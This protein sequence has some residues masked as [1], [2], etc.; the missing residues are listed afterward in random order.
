[1]QNFHVPQ[2]F[3]APP[4]ES[5]GGANI[6]QVLITMTSLTVSTQQLILAFSQE[7]S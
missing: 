6:R 1:M 7:V 5:G 2:T 3:N 4:Q